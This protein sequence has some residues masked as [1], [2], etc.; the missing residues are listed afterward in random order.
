MSLSGLQPHGARGLNTIVILLVEMAAFI[1]FV[2]LKTPVMTPKYFSL[3]AAKGVY[4]ILLLAYKGVYVCVRAHVREGRWNGWVQAAPC[5]HCS[6]AAGVGGSTPRPH[7]IVF[8]ILY[9]GLFKT[10]LEYSNG[11]EP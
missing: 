7:S 8:R 11:I 2:R 3:Y 9:F 5:V 4:V 10:N 1:C 6:G